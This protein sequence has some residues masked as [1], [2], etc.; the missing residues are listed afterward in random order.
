L[1]EIQLVDSNL[2]LVGEAFDTLTQSV[3]LS[4]FLTLGDQRLA[5]RFESAAP[6]FQFLATAQK[7]LPLDEIRLVEI[8]NSPALGSSGF[9]LAIE[10][11]NLGSEQLVV[12]GLASPRHCG[13]ACEQQLWA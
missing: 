3:L 6:Q 2:D 1:V 12:A 13:L 8:S 10:P 4:Q 7:L 11:G 9:D 5:L